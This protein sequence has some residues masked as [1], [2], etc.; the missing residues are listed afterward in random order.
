MKFPCNQT[1]EEYNKRMKKF[2]LLLGLTLS[3]IGTSAF[4]ESFL[5]DEQRIYTQNNKC[6]INYLTEKNTSGWYAETNREECGESG[7]LTGYHNITIYNAFSKPIEKLYGYFSNGYWTG[8]SFLKQV[9]FNRFSDELGI[10]K[11]TFNFSGENKPSG[12]HYIG[13]MVTK[14]TSSGTY[15]AFRVCSPMR[16]LGI[17][18][19][20][21]KL[22]DPHFLQRIFTYVERKVRLMCP[23][24]EQVMLFLS[25]SDNPKQEEI[26]VFVRMNLKNR[27]HKIIRADELRA[28]PKPLRIKSEKGKTLSVFLGKTKPSE[29]TSAKEAEDKIIANAELVEADEISSEDI[30]ESAV[31]ILTDTV[32]EDAPDNETSASDKT[33]TTEKSANKD[34]T[35]KTAQQR[36]TTATQQNKTNAHSKKPLSSA[37]Q[38]A[39]DAAAYFNS[40]GDGEQGGNATEDETFRIPRPKKSYLQPLGKK[41]ERGFSDRFQE[42]FA[43]RDISKTIEPLANVF[44]ISKVLNAPVIARSAVHI[45]AMHMDNTGYALRPIP[46]NLEGKY[47]PEGWHIIKGYYYAYPDGET[48]SGQGVIRIIGAE[49]CTRAICREKL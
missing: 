8:D 11:A 34:N 22:D 30:P 41:D 44:L 17:V 24:D 49:E 25:S 13:Q 20:V 3:F 36:A 14:K 7:A 19:D 47:V 26:A 12:M 37:E 48:E 18:D 38:A 29:T 31:E 9:E 16:V 27:R 5:L 6:Y 45:D 46:T 40:G 32:T 35:A 2:T 39:Q 21:K 43:E 1:K 10:Q 33:D 28:V 42:Q 15:P 4:A 23:M